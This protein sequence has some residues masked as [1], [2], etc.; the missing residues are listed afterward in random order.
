MRHNS[1]QSP[2][3]LGF[4]TWAPHPS[5]LHSHN[6]WTTGDGLVEW[7]ER[8]QQ[9]SMQNRRCGFSVF[10]LREWWRMPNRE[11]KRVPNHSSDVFK[12]YLPQGPPAHPPYLSHLLPQFTPTHPILLSTDIMQTY[13]VHGEHLNI[14]V[15]LHQDGSCRSLVQSAG[16]HANEAVLHQVHSPHSMLPSETRHKGS[17]LHICL[18][19]VEGCKC[20]SP[21]MLSWSLVNMQLSVW[22][23]S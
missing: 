19:S 7:E 6:T 16:F 13:P 9:I 17:C 3:G 12:G 2:T 5:P 22:V 1:C 20:L 15:S 23:W 4:H 21:S 10:D 18:I 11:R 8:K 14:G